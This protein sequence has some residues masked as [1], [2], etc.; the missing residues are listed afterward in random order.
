MLLFGYQWKT[1]SSIS[2]FGDV[3]Y[4]SSANQVDHMYM[5][6]IRGFIK[7]WAQGKLTACEHKLSLLFLMLSFQHNF[8]C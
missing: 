3:R 2:V 5:Y 8:T 6:N 4:M 7:G 1:F